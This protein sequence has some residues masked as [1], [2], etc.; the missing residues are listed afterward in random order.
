MKKIN[1]Q[2]KSAE[3]IYHSYIRRI[4]RTLSVLPKSDKI[5]LLMEYN[6]HIYEGLQSYGHK[7]EVE[8]LLQITQ[9]LGDPEVFLKPLVAERKL[10]QATKTFNP[11]HIFQAIFL[12]IGNGF[13]YSLFALLYLCLFSFLF[14]IITKILYG[15]QVGLYIN[16]GKFVALGIL[17]AGP[18]DIE[19]LGSWFIPVLLI[20][21]VLLYLLITFL[22]KA[23]K[24]K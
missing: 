3:K 1:F 6:S 2:D 5:D 24:R 18:G 13:V 14:L 22:L 11:K 15:T 17:D 4:D 16:D 20:S 21:M 10:I 7:S 9:N 8:R 12:N 23:M 19:V